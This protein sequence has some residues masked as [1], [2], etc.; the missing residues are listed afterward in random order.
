MNLI[1]KSIKKLEKYCL[2]AGFETGIA[3]LRIR[4]DGERCQFPKGMLLEA[5]YGGETGYIIT[6]TPLEAKTRLS[7]LFGAT[8]NTPEKRASACAI[9]NAV[10]RFLCLNRCNH[11]CDRE[12]QK[13]CFK[14]LKIEIL[15]KKVFLVGD[16]PP[17]KYMPGI[18]I[19]EQPDFADILIVG[20]NGITKEDCLGIIDVWEEKKRFVYIGPSTSGIASLEKKEH[21]CPYGW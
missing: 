2:N 20:G 4:Q 5:E 15:G 8:L 10:T 9:I 12:C 16:L 21:W 6:N 18:E 11:A 19:V 13:K 1:E 17:I 7:F 14:E 3:V